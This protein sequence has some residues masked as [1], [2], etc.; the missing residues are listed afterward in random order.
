MEKRVFTFM[1]IFS[2]LFAV[3][4]ASEKGGNRREVE[5]LVREFE[6]CANDC[7]TMVNQIIHGRE[8]LNSINRIQKKLNDIQARYMYYIDDFTEDD[9][10]R[11]AKASE[12]MAVANAKLLTWAE[13]QDLQY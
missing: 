8:P 7:V 11:I 10:N 3:V 4:S 2:M 9:M 6:T 12:K 5:S 13:Q 1:I